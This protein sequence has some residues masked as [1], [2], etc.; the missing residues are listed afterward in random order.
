MSS[1][2]FTEENIDQSLET[3][4][5]LEKIHEEEDNTPIFLSLVSDGTAEGTFLRD[6]DKRPVPNFSEFTVGMDAH[7][8]QVIQISFFAMPVEIK[9]RPQI[10][11][12]N[13]SAKLTTLDE[14]IAEHEA[15][16][17]ELHRER[18][19]A[20]SEEE[21]CAAPGNDCDRKD[22]IVAVPMAT[23]LR[24]LGEAKTNG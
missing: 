14:L 2:E 8:R 3:E 23:T 19:N 20:M 7:G 11:G 15:I 21:G 22:V 10:L 18:L 4:E 9:T 24:D 1:T 5:A 6:Q 13:L 17:R 16:V 12:S